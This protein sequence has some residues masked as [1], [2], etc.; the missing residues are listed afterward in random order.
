MDI[1]EYWEKDL[2]KKECLELFENTENFFEILKLADG[3]RRE[4]VGDDVTYVVNRNINFT[5]VCVGDCKFCAF[6]VDKGDK[7]AY[8]LNPD[9]IAKKALE[10][11]KIGAT[12]VCIQG[13]LHPDI[14]TYF[15]VEILK[16]VHEITKPYGDIHI[17]AF[18]PMEIKF[19]A[20]NAGLDVKEALNILYENGLNTMPGTA[21]EI[22][23]D[24]IRNEL[25]PSKLSTNEWVKIVKTAHKIGIPTTSTMMYGH[26]EEYKHMVNHLFVIKEIQEET[27]GFTEFVPLSF[28]HKFAPIYNMGTSKGGATGLEDLKVYAISRILF[29]DTLKNIQVSWVKLGLKMAQIALKCGANDFGGTLMEENIS[30]AAGAEY[31]VSMNSKEIR[32]AIIR[33]GRAPKERNTLYEILE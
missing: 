9:H 20:E 15:Q 22:L 30:K 10:A 13:G 5:N 16:K 8:F 1:M 27:G 25:C 19:A 32:D 26:I 17:H 23:D 18:S 28:M 6:K 12:E 7:E 29:K 2:S 4:I 11:K 24:E 21:A 3:M 31:G 33:I 14:D